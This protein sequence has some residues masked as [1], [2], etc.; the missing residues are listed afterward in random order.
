MDI[1]N[2][3]GACDK[4]PDGRM[5]FG[6]VFRLDGQL[7]NG[8]GQRT[9]KSGNTNN[10]AEYTALKK[11]LEHYIRLNGKGPLLVKGDSKL[12]I[13]QM[14]GK[15][16]I[17]NTALR[18]LATQI[19]KFIDK[20]DLIIKYEWIPREKNSIADNLAAPKASSKPLPRNRY[21][22]DVRQ[23]PIPKKLQEHIIKIN[24]DPSPGFKAMLKLKVG[25]RDIF[26]GK[27][28]SELVTEAGPDV[29]NIAKKQF[30]DN[31]AAQASVLR[32]MLRGLAVDH[33]VHKVKVDLKVNANASSKRRG[34][35]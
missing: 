4:N 8:N 1:L 12:V 27:P 3:D 32:W 23:A 25:G 21:V 24:R 16:K 31:E 33:A 30:A 26:S 15:W 6:W 19:N 7:I 18:Q 13:N 5:G 14:A 35:R 20:H 2:F 22:A 28:L 11:G 17:S 9:P 10:V 34:V 29:S